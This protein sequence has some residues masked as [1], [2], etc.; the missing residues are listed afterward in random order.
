MPELKFAP[1]KPALP[2][3]KIISLLTS[4][5]IV[6]ILQG[7]K[8]RVYQFVMSITLRIYATHTMYVQVILDLGEAHN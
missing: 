7:H 8:D 1:I 3:T 4:T 5:K 2:V 6:S